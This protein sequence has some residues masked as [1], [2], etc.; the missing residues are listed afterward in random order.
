M[1]SACDWNKEWIRW[2]R[3]SWVSFCIL[4]FSVEIYKVVNITLMLE[5]KHVHQILYMWFWVW[6]HQF[7][8]CHFISSVKKSFTRRFCTFKSKISVF[9]CLVNGTIVAATNLFLICKSL[10]FIECMK[11]KKKIDVF[12][13]KVTISALTIQKHQNVFLF[14][15]GNVSSWSLYEI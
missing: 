12:L 15:L 11:W 7:Q 2:I 10:S 13:W 1:L 14:W 6:E 8:I 5:L 4:H 3:F 9:S